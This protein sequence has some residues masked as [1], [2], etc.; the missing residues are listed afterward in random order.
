M[1][2][3]TAADAANP[4]GA[5]NPAPAADSGARDPAT[6]APTGQ[7]HRAD[8]T[9]PT[10]NSAVSNPS[11]DPRPARPREPFS[12][13]ALGG[14]TVSLL[15]PTVFLGSTFGGWWPPLLLTAVL[16]VLLGLTVG[17]QL[18]RLSRA[19]TGVCCGVLVIVAGY[20]MA[21][22]GPR[23][24]PDSMVARPAW[25]VLFDAVASLLS[26]PVGTPPRAD[27][28]APGLL[29]V[30]LLSTAVLVRAR[31]R[32]PGQ[33]MGIAPAIAAPAIYAAG[34][35][36]TAGQ[37]DRNGLIAGALVVV[38]I[39]SW[40]ALSLPTVGA[41]AACALAATLVAFTA[42][43]PGWDARQYVKPPRIVVDQQNLLPYL[44][45]WRV[46]ADT[47]VFAVSGVVPDR[48]D[49]A[50]YPRYDGTSWGTGADFALFG[51]ARPA[52]LPDGR[53]VAGYRMT[54][55]QQQL[56]GDWL[57][58]AGRVTAVSLPDVVQDLVG[59]ALGRIGQR[60]APLP[61][62]VTGTIDVADDDALSLS[63]VPDQI[64]AG[65]YLAIPQLSPELSAWVRTTVGSAQG[66]Y[67]Q[68]AA[69]ESALRA[70]HAADPKADTGSGLYAVTD[71][72]GAGGKPP[73]R[74]AAPETFVTAFAVL[75][76]SVGIPSRVV[77]GARISTVPGVTEQNRPV[78][79]R[80]MSVWPEL[81]FADVGWVAFDP[82][83]GPNKSDA[84]KHREK[85]LAQQSDDEQA[86]DDT[87]VVDPDAPAPGGDA[88]SVG[89]TIA[90]TIGAVAVVLATAMVCG[91]LVL[92]RR[93][94]RAGAAGAWSSIEQGAVLAGLRPAAG[95]SAERLV[96]AITTA[97][98]RNAG[99]A[100]AVVARQAQRQRFGPPGTAVDSDVRRQASIVRKALWHSRPGLT[101][102][103]WFVRP[104]YWWP[105][106]KV[107][108]PESGTARKR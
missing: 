4:A 66:R 11:A 33:P 98:G 96:G 84:Q 3:R 30:G 94:R 63:G 14:S 75:A 21:S 79:G 51:S 105:G 34:Q 48:I 8:T 106:G 16:L 18:L 81:Y 76:R 38:L 90:L 45:I 78:R 50:V 101:R 91:A 102:V 55:S 13:R 25:R 29:L 59:G 10:G 72:V 64:A 85:E 2:T 27:L 19:V 87:P 69:L 56:P 60:A 9:P 28:V 35:I 83:P 68:A 36:L 47:V 23:V 54:V 5:G 20:L 42:P 73:A 82:V 97:A 95:W 17:M 61:Y 39:L 1:T 71:L 32:A 62:E 37:S 104:G 74:A 26:T 24:G 86:Q 100:A 88:S 92:R 107:T 12:W 46:Q 31:R 103:L 89:G 67:D 93:W 77:V 40:T 49:V 7:D 99:R 6:T 41:A 44:G 43:A 22:G 58:A 108:L 53:Y 15:V 52:A 70:G 57:P 80:D 65:E